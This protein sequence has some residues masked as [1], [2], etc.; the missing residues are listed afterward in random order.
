MSRIERVT[1][2]AKGRKDG[3]QAVMMMT[4]ASML[5]V[6]SYALI[7]SLFHLHRPTRKINGAI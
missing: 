2:T 1:D 4:F 5:D 6:K 3:I 7:V